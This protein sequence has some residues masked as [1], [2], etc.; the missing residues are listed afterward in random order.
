MR[1]TEPQLPGT[2][3]REPSGYPVQDGVTCEAGFIGECRAVDQRASGDAEG[4][5]DRRKN[6]A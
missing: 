3:L 4:R 6:C 5:K 1:S 2:T